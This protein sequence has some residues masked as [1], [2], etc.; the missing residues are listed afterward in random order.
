MQLNNWKQYVGQEEK[1]YEGK[2]NVPIEIEQAFVK[3]ESEDED[4]MNV[5]DEVSTIQ[6]VYS[7]FEIPK[8]F[9]LNYV[10]LK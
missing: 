8:E 10:D 4:E 1:K 5:G 9:Y 6:K 2:E 7:A 3:N